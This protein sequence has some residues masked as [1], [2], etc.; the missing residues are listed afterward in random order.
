LLFLV[1]AIVLGSVLA[2]R[3]ASPLH[4]VALD[5]EKVGRF[6]LSSMLAPSSF[7]T[8]IAVVGE[9]VDRMKAG[10][11]SFSRYVP[12]EVVGDLLA[13]G[14]EARLG[15]E[16]R[17]LTIFFSDID[18]FTRIAE[19]MEPDRLVEHLSEYLQEMTAIVQD[20]AGTIDKFLGDGILAFF[21]AP[22][23]LPDHVARACRAAVRSQERLHQLRTGWE[24]RGA[25]AFHARIGLEVG[26]VLVGNIG[27][28]DRF[29]YTVVGDAVNLANR[30]E[31]LNKLYGTSILAS[32]DIRQAAGSDFEWRTVD[33]VAV[34]GREESTL[35]C[36]LLG[37]GGAT[38]P[39]VLRARD[40]YEH[41]LQAYMDGRF[42]EA[43]TRFREAAVLRPGD[44]AAAIMAG[45][46]ETLAR[47]ERSADWSGVYTQLEK[48]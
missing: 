3:V 2:H 27:T 34:V 7:V 23:D 31:S 47:E 12:T 16:Y 30:L 1:I 19:H 26:E 15:V 24:G 46:C 28:P 39:G 4:A 11:R 35:V 44:R 21:N 29:E 45:R 38:D 41:G 43:E 17:R 25:P 6:E 9:S 40:T 10:L 42:T 32:A 18:G 20:E 36:E 8:E 33:R 22:L 48:L 13:R 5:L 37:E 14:E